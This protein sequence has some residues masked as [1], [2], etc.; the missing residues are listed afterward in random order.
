VLLNDVHSFSSKG[1]G[2]LELMIVGVAALK[3]ALDVVE[4]K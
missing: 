1:S 3:G 4:V 2:D